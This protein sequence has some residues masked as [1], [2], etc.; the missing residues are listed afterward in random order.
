L[1]QSLTPHRQFRSDLIG[2]FFCDEL[3][4]SGLLLEQQRI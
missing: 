4:E 3:V 1:E 2:V